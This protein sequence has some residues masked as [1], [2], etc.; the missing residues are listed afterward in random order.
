MIASSFIFISLIY[1][2]HIA[3]VFPVLVRCAA[4]DTTA[5]RRGEVLSLMTCRASALELLLS[6]VQL[7]SFS[8]QLLL[9][10]Q[11]VGLGCSSS[12]LNKEGKKHFSQQTL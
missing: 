7:S 6:A 3:Y 1:D 2:A 11:Q 5:G 10:L 12:R 8:L 9:L 4:S